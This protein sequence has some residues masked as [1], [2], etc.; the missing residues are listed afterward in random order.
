[1]RSHLSGIARLLLLVSFFFLKG[2]T[3]HAQEIT[4]FANNDRVVF[5]GNS[6]TDG[7]HYHSYIGLY[8]MTRFPAMNLSILNA[9][10]GGDRVIEMVKR[11]DGDVF[12]KRPTVLVTTFGMNDSGYFEYN[13]DEPDKFADEKVKESYD[14]YQEMEKRYKQIP[15]I[16]IVLMGSSPYDEGAIIKDNTPFKGKNDAML[17]IVDF[18]KASAQSNHW[19][20]FDLNQP[21]TQ[22]NQ[23]IQQ[24]DSTF[25]LCGGDRIHPDND[26]HMV[27]AYLFLKAQGFAGNKVA[28]LSIDATRQQVVSAVNCQLSTI[29]KTA[30]G[31][32]FDYKANALPYP[33]DTVARGWGSKKSQYDALRVIPFME[34]MNQEQLVVTGLKGRHKLVIDGEVIGVWSA[35]DFARGINLAT[36]SHTPQYQQA[37]GVMYLNEERWEIERRFR[38][39]AWVQYNFFQPRGLLDANNRKAIDVMDEHVATDGWLRA[40][41]DLY[42][43]AMLPEVRK[44]WQDQIDQLTDAMREA[45]IPKTRKITLVSVQ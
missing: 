22:L 21:M 10:I 29:K 23:H 7:G 31:I 42:A 9:G 3:A 5:L 12:S 36:L 6:I 25:T 32:S 20:F 1:M 39:Y 35:D 43:R 38:D 40:K 34:E 16:R 8:Y 33:L 37:L 24:Q 30:A 15:G 26:G 11:L 13:G 45:A 17:R 14:A 19:E 4:P 27:M 2:M 44:S 28:E 41:R 18:Q